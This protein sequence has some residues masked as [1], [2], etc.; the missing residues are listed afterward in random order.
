MRQNTSDAALKP[1][2]SS[3]TPKPEFVAQIPVSVV[4][5]GFQ[6]LISSIE[7]DFCIRRL[8]L[9][10]CLRATHRQMTGPGTDPP[11]RFACYGQAGIRSSDA[12]VAGDY[13]NCNKLLCSGYTFKKRDNPALIYKP[14]MF[15]KSFGLSCANIFPHHRISHNPIHKNRQFNR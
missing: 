7:P 12:A 2:A 14:I 13:G 9:N 11:S 8:F 4:R 10:T 3:L 1:H 15:F 6:F 5:L